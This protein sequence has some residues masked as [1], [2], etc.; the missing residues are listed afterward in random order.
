[1]RR[2]R[3]GVAAS[4]DGFIAGPNGEADWIVMDPEIDFAKFMSEIDTYLL[5][6]HTFEFV[7]AAGGGVGGGGGDE[8]MIVFSRTL[9]PSEY[10]DTRIVSEGADEVVA[11]LKAHP[12]K[13]IWL[14][15]GGS[16]FASLLAAG[17]V[18]TV[19]VAVMPVLLGDGVPLMAAPGPRQRLVLREHQVYEKTG[20]VGLSYDVEERPAPS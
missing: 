16:L 19:E 2:V 17:L 18:D 4:L 5:G 15:G 11:E 8:R 6:R 14:F 3:Y 20:I 1:M 12:G 7:R 9:D 13:D 10:P